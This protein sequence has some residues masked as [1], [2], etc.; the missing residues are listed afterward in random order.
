MQLMLL[1]LNAPRVP[2]VPDA[3]EA[4][5]LSR[6]ANDFL[7]EQAARQPDWFQAL[8][9]LPLQDPERASRELE[10]SVKELGFRAGQ[11]LFRGRKCR[12]TRL[13]SR[14]PAPI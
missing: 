4:G 2:A 14:P 8:D 6:R 13:P 1:S 9:A 3:V 7:A 12:G 11:W 5:Q 10:R